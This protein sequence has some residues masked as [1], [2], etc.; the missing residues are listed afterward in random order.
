MRRD[1][2]RKLLIVIAILI[3]LVGIWCLVDLNTSNPVIEGTFVYG[4]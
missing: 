4:R 2:Y 1:N 3:I